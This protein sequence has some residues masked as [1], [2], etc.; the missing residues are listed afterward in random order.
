MNDI[1][2]TYPHLHA[3]NHQQHP[4]YQLPF[5]STSSNYDLYGSSSHGPYYNNVNVTYN[6]H[7]GYQA[8]DKPELQPAIR[9]NPMFNIMPPIT[10]SPIANSNALPPKAQLPKPVLTTNNTNSS[11]LPHQQ[12]H[13][14]NILPSATSNN[15][16]NIKVKLQD[17]S[18]WKS[19]NEVG[20]EMIITKT[21]RLVYLFHFTIIGNSSILINFCFLDACFHLYVLAYQV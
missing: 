2:P 7:H 12:H 9:T 20:T 6:Y 10:S 3:I 8:G 17:M 11:T 18:L 4:H 13:I 15:N 16:P 5:K 1:H 14:D 21:G 19:F